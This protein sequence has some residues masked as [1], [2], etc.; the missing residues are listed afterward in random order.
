MMLDISRKLFF[1]ELAGT[2]ASRA[3][4]KNQS[5]SGQPRNGHR[6]LADPDSM[7]GKAKQAREY[8]VRL[9]AET[10]FWEMIGVEVC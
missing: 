6:G 7:S 9:I 10:A 1:A 3:K 2:A 8:G 5:S 4:R